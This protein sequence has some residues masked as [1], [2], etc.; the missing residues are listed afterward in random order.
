M[1]K[2]G[3]VVQLNSGG[4]TMT[5]KQSDSDKT[6]C[7]WFDNDRGDFTVHSLPTALL[8]LV[9]LGPEVVSAAS[10]DYE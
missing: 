6:T 5:V 2:V 10:E 1:F 3:D 4:P 7:C 8:H 9:N